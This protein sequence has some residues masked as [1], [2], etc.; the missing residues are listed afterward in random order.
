MTSSSL[1]R[2]ARV[3]RT[4]NFSLGGP[5]IRSRSGA[6]GLAHEPPEH[7][8]GGAVDHAGVVQAQRL[9]PRPE[10]RLFGENVFFSIVT[11]NIKYL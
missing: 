2:W 11:Y 4:A 10:H 8:H 7:L 5:N 3:Y 1:L 9:R 6:P